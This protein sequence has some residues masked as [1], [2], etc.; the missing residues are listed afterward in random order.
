M[1]NPTKTKAAMLNE[2]ESIKGLL[3]EQDDIPILQEEVLEQRPTPRR[4][5]LL[6]KPYKSRMLT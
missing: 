4:H 3:L 1:G 2:L 6:V 5:L